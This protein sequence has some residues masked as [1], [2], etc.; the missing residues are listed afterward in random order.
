M[1]LSDR[2]RIPPAA[3]FLRRGEPIARRRLAFPVKRTGKS[4][5]RPKSDRRI[6]FRP[7]EIPAVVLAG[8][9]PLQKIQNFCS[10]VRNRGF[11]LVGDSVWRW[12]CRY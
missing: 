7:G 6:P 12:P 5:P 1:P 3:V 8:G 2:S 11:D 10:G 4:K 9:L